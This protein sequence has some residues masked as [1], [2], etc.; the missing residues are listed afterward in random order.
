MRYQTTESRPVLIDSYEEVPEIL[1]ELNHRSHLQDVFI[2][3]S[4]A[5]FAP[6]G[7]DKFH[8]LCRL[9]GTELINKNFNII[10]GFGLGV[11]DQVI[12]GA[13][14]SLKRNDDE[15]LQ[16]WPFPQKVPS[17]V[18]R[19]NFWREYR[20]RMIS[21]AGVCIVLSGNKKS[22]SGAIVPANGVQQEVE[23]ALSQG[24]IV[25]PIGATGHVARDIFDKIGA[26][27]SD[28]YGAVNVTK[29][30]DVLG[31]QAASAQIL[32]D[33]IINLLKLMEK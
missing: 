19:A 1:K 4:A 8:E 17:G 23:I 6:L 33:A 12:I 2:S 7:E 16:L 13:M 29:Y 3:G 27:P 26:N 21:N 24:K 32:V 11:G 31:N 28:Y 10:S 14:Q 5:D 18:D 20:E 30:L 15:R 22:E 25:I 9:L